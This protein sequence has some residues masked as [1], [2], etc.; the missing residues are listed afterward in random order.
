MERIIKILIERDGM[1]REEA[2]AIYTDVMEEVCWYITNNMFDYA[3]QAFE[4][5]FCLELDYFPF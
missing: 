1:T 5:G 3:E 4:S 2:E